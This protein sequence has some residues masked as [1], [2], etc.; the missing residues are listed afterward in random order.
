MRDPNEDAAVFAK[1]LKILE[2]LETVRAEPPEDPHALL[3]EYRVLADAYVKL[4]RNTRKITR[5]ADSSQNK[6]IKLRNKL[7]SANKAL[8]QA[9]L[10]D[11]LTGLHNR[12]YLDTFM[13][14]DIEG[15]ARELE[16]GGHRNFLFLLLDIDHFKQV[17]DNHG[18]GAGDEVL[19]QIAAILAANCRRGDISVRWGGEEFL[20][21]CRDINNPDAHALAERLRTSIAQ[22]V[23]KVSDELEL[24]CTVSIGFA[25]YPF[26]KQDPFKVS[27]QQVIDFAD[28]G[29]Y[30]AK[31][32]SRDA[33]V[34]VLVDRED[35]QQPD[36]TYLPIPTDGKERVR[37]ST[38]LPVGQEIVW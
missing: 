25:F 9:S 17:N 4:L 33:W 30:A 18:H 12:R 13:E 23:F 29:L 19:K 37:I 1:E 7:A 16:Q 11:A 32:T 31:R 35:E 28:Q 6:L 22:S 20:M 5:L 34:G 8:E 27:W 21:V 26:F 10:T 36:T 15:V 14:K 2:R 3:E 38:S 24:H